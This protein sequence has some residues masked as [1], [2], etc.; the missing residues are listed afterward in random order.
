M[1]KIQAVVDGYPGLT[2]DLLTYLRERIKEVLTGA[3][4]TIVVRIFGPDLDRARRRRPAKC[5]R[6]SPDIDGVADLTQQQLTLVPQVHVRMR[7]E[8][9][10]IAGRDAAASP[11]HRRDAPPGPQGRR[12]LRGAEDLRRRRLGRAAARAP[13]C[14]RSSAC[15]STPRAGGYVP[16]E[17]VADVALAPTPNE[18][19][20]EGGSRRIDVTTNV[21]GRDLGA[22]AR[23]IKSGAR[24]RAVP[25]GLSRRV[26]RRVRRARSVA[27]AAADPRPA[28]AARHPAGPARRLRIGAAGRAGR[29]DPAVRAD[30]RRGGG[31]PL[32]RR[33]VARI[34]RRLRHGARHRRA[35]RHHARQPLPASAG[36]RKACRSGASS[37]CAAPR[38]GSR[39]S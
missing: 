33:A 16:L 36:D 32:G 24:G 20:R 35:Q 34:A 26:A 23:D 3:S 21:R 28:V 12:N 13:T 1:A 7:P 17:A 11:R 19:T 30:R 31:V 10:Q 18:I 2:R 39:R 15:R 9:A 25:G 4:A 22:V 29:A 8:R 6:R 14:S 38:S 5:G 37:C 27:A